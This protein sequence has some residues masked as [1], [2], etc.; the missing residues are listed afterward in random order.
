MAFENL[1]LFEFRFEDAQFGPRTMDQSEEHE[2]EVE[3]APDESGRSPLA[4]L[5]VIGLVA[6][7]SVL[8]WRRFRAGDADVD[9]HYEEERASGGTD[10]P[11]E[12]DFTAA[13]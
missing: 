12:S 3:A 13:E 7:V 5:F 6:L 4:P 11:A 10:E 2:E 8:A 1:T 9:V